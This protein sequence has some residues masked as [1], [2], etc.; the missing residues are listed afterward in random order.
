MPLSSGGFTLPNSWS[1]SLRQL[2]SNSSLMA[3]A[4]CSIRSIFACRLPDTP[5]VVNPFVFSLAFLCAFP[6]VY[7]AFSFFANFQKQTPVGSVRRGCVWPTFKGI[8]SES[9][10]ED[11]QNNGNGA[12]EPMSRLEAVVA[13]WHLEHLAMTTNR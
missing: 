9:G 2:P 12:T 8:A 10:Q 3:L 1:I 4:S 6:I 5:F 11:W 7:P 13:V